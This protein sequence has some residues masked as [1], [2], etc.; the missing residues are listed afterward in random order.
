[1]QLVSLSLQQEIDQKTYS[2]F[3]EQLTLNKIDSLYCLLTNINKERFI[4]K[5]PKL[6]SWRLIHRF[7][8]K[9]VKRSKDLLFFMSKLFTLHLYAYK[10]V[11]DYFY[12]YDAS[13]SGYPMLSLLFKSNFDGRNNVK[14]CHDNYTDIVEKFQKAM[15]EYLLAYEK[16]ITVLRPF[17][18]NE[19]LVNAENQTKEE[20]NSS[21]MKIHKDFYINIHNFKV[22][23]KCET[24][25]GPKAHLLFETFISIKKNGKS[26]RV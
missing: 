10:N 24:L 21:I 22:F 26:R 18:C 8:M 13:A 19:K 4:L 7:A 23:D 25:L 15:T 2:E 9:Y 17:K 14:N 6:I 1:M 12:G 5:L 3:E 20:D 16:C 11:G